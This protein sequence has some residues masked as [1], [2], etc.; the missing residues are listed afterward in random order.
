M[1]DLGDIGAAIVGGIFGSAGQ[2]S[3]NRANLKI[4]REQMKFQERMSNTAHQREVADLK[5]AGL[6]PLL[7]A[8]GSGASTPG[9]ASA[10]MENEL[11]DFARAPETIL[12]LRKARADI[13][14]T[15]AQEAYIKA[16]EEGVDLQNELTK[17]TIKWYENHPQ[18]APN[19]PGGFTTGTGLTQVGD[20]LWSQLGRAR[21]WFAGQLNKGKK[22]G[23]PWWS[24]GKK[25]SK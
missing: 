4:A 25:Q 17:Q 5:A 14:Q 11:K 7:S 1:S 15:R 8:G 3:A 23:T 16:Q 12:A 2:N 24:Y 9:G 20:R 10:H 18:F 21:D 13:S 19:V 22:F 6:N